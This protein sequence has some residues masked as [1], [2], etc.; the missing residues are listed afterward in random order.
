V[1]P[2]LHFFLKKK[3]NSKSGVFGLDEE[4][5]TIYRQKHMNCRSWLGP[6]LH[7]IPRSKTIISGAYSASKYHEYRFTP[8]GFSVLAVHRKIRKANNHGLMKLVTHSIYFGNH[9]DISMELR[10]YFCLN[11]QKHDTI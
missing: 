1:P 6:L 9:L 5:K 2:P 8:S 11:I 3:S 7:V 4:N 10:F